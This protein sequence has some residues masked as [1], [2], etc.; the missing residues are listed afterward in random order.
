M[1]Q[2]ETTIIEPWTTERVVEACAQ[3]ASVAET[4]VGDL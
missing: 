2:L 1:M 4:I 3:A